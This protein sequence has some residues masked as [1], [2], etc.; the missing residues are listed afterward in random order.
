VRYLKKNE[1]LL[2]RYIIKKTTVRFLSLLT[3]ILL[4]VSII[5]GCGSSKSTP[6]TTST[7][8]TTEATTE[9][10]TKAAPE[11]LVELRWLTAQI[12]ATNEAQWL[13]DTVN[14][15]NEKY[16]GKIKIN[17]DGV[18]GEAVNDKL[19]T[20]AAADTMPDLF[21]LYAD[22]ARFSVMAESGRV[23]DLNPYLDKNPELKDRIDK[24]SAAAYTDK[25]GKLLGLP[26]VKGY[27]GIFYN[28]DLFNK[29]GIS[30]FPTTWDEFNEACEKLLKINVAPIA[31]MTGENSWTTMLILTDILG[32]DPDGN[33]WLKGKPEEANF[34][35]P[36]FIKAVK[37]L[38][39]ILSKY[40]NKDAIGATYAVVANN[41]LNGKAAMIANGPWMIGDFSNPQTAMPGLDKNV[42]YALAPGNGTIQMENMSYAS[43]SKDQDKKDA[44]FEVLKF[45][46]SDEIYIPYLNLTGN[47]PCL[48]VDSSLLELDPI[49]ATFM[50]QALNAKFKYGL[51]SDAIKPAVNDALSQLLPD[52]ANGKLTPEEFAQK[53]QEISDKN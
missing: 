43:G 15:F 51:F 26:Y 22:R 48:K 6:S 53:M 38:Q 37:E 35:S 9:E 1:E 40:S 49:N 23:V 8:S 52:L 19:K 45:L 47:A 7:G 10:T 20:D 36:A 24:D 25:D 13:T 32:T 14:K 27:V 16:A 30:S 28:T 42:A 12:G 39:L 2:G 3:V 18:G 46:A 29:A 41:F 31:M 44:S 50:T 11:K 4:M 21:M 33:A 17:I 34:N 5:T